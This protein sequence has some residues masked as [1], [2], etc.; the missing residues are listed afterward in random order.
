MISVLRQKGTPTTK[1]IGL[2]F[3]VWIAP[4]KMIRVKKIR[5]NWRDTIKIWILFRTNNTL[6]QNSRIASFQVM[7]WAVKSLSKLM[8]KERIWGAAQDSAWCQIV[9]MVKMLWFRPIWIILRVKRIRVANKTPTPLPWAWVARVSKNKKQILCKKTM[10]IEMVN[11]NKDW[12]QITTQIII[13]AKQDRSILI[14][15][16]LQTTNKMKKMR[17]QWETLTKDRATPTIINRVFQGLQICPIA[18]LTISR[19]SN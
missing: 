18:K 19:D 9:S 8:V 7:A 1:S 11:L 12:R 5:I 6:L 3:W 14:S 16:R 2:H 10:Q 13:W 15:S 17:F 4:T